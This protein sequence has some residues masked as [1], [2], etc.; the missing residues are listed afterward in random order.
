[1]ETPQV[2]SK[3]ETAPVTEP[4][5]Q[6][7]VEEPEPAAGLP[8][9]SAGLALPLLLIGMVGVGGWWRRRNAL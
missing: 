7:F 8:V 5:Y 4:S 1:V 6:E 2:I 9:C 3:V